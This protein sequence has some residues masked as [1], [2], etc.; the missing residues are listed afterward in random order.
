M[1]RQPGPKLHNLPLQLTSFI[2]R[3]AEIAQIS[4]RLTDPLC[5]LLTV[6]GTGGI[7]KT[8]LAIQ[9]AT[10]LIDN[11]DQGVYFVPLQGIDA[12]EFLASAVAEAVDFPLSGQQEPLAQV[13]NY[14]SDKRMLLLLDNFEQLV[15]QNGPVIMIKILAAAPAV[16][17]LVTS[18]EVLNLQEEWLYPLPGLPVP[19]TLQMVNGK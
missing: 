4:K 19:D 16:K 15:E 2:G 9:A 13:L 11:F 10:T 5:R 12:G 7:G 1:P 3:D 6:V 14:L 8:R 17:L 18:R